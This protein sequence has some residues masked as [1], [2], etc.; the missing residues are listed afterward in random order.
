MDEMV[1]TRPNTCPDANG[2]LPACTPL[3][4]PFV[5]FQQN[6]PQ[7]YTAAAGMIRGTLYPGLDLPF[8]NQVNTQEK[9][10]TLRHQIQALSFAVD[11]LGLY[12]DTHSTDQ[13]AVDLFN[14]YVERYEDVVQQYESQFGAL[15]QMSSAMEGTYDW[16]KDP[17]PWDYRN[18]EER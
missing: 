10:A 17:W 12:L 1:A 5:P 2:T 6:N 4:V 15:T 11:E 8:Q 3:A 16:L 7:V 13:D 9:T 18:K 14:Q